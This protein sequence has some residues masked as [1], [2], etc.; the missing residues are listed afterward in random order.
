MSDFHTELDR[1]NIAYDAKLSAVLNDR[2]E[3]IR[4]LCMEYDERG[5]Q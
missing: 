1:L 4:L 2:A 5:R 3:A